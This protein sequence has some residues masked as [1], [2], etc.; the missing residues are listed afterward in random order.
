MD[1][2]CDYIVGL[3]VTLDIQIKNLNRR[4]SKNVSMDLLINSTSKFDKVVDK[5]DYII[6]NL[7]TLDDLKNE[8][9]KTKNALLS[10]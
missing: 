8:Y 1:T 6:H 7:G 10:I 5:L 2:M 4:N 3:D 9:I